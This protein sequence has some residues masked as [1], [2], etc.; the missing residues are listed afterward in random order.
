VHIQEIKLKGPF[1]F[2]PRQNKGN[3]QKKIKPEIMAKEIW[4]GW[5]WWWKAN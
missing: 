4:F 3:N 2:C 5:W 1:N